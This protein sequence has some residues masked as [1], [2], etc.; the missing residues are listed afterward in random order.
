MN[1]LN[2]IEKRA[3]FKLDTNQFSNIKNVIAIVSGK[4]GVGKSLVT[5]ILAIEMANRGYKTAILDA[6]ITGPSIPK[7]FGLNGKLSGGQKGIE[8]IST[9]KGVKIVSTNLLIDTET[10]AVVWRA[11]MLTGAIRQFWQ[12]ITWGEID[13]MFVD[14]PPGTSDAQ[15]T[16]FQSI[17]IMGIV[18]VTSPQELVLMIVEK[19]MDMATKVDIPVIGVIEN[20]S[21]F[22]AP[23]T[24]KKYEIFGKSKTHHM[25]DKYNL[26]LLANIP[27]R[28]EISEMVDKGKIEKLDTSFMSDAID[29]IL[30]FEKYE[31]QLK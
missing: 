15:L 12:D 6:D 28:P 17:P 24:K 27:I 19:A 16:I 13:Y 5:S 18:I 4:G 3:L 20:F 31:A 11:P 7:A 26:N 30:E 25:L 29:K 22:E 2:N 21:Y 14:L 10:Q 8:A 1:N 23:D 9:K